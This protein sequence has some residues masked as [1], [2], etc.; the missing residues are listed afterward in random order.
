[1]LSNER[2]VLRLCESGCPVMLGVVSTGSFSVQA[3]TT[4]MLTDEV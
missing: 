2:R 1:M 4:T 3:E